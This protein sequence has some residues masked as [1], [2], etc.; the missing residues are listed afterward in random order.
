MDL[1]T[2]NSL[3]FDQT[4]QLGETITYDLVLERLSETEKTYHL[5]VLN[6]P[7]ELKVHFKDAEKGATVSAVKF[8]QDVT[9]KQL[10]MELVIP[11]E[12]PQEKLDKPVAFYVLVLDEEARDRL[13]TL[14]RSRAEEE[15]SEDDLRADRIAHER[16]VFTPKGVGR[17]ELSS[18]DLYN[19]I[20]AGDTLEIK[21]K[22]KNIGSVALRNIR[23]QLELPA[24]WEAN[25]NPEVIREL[26]L[27]AEETVAI[28]LYPSPDLGVGDYTVRVDADCSYEGQ[29]ITIDDKIVRIHV[30]SKA[31]VLGGIVLLLILVGALVGIAVFLVRLARR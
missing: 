23:V 26:E 16:V 30:E 4:G 3:N 20:T 21:F 6:L 28:D 22:V 29:K 9:K 27:A 7:P 8:A 10:G 18:P 2:V 14:K 11:E 5:S 15:I 19:E 24:D 1:P 17:C 31:N 25:T 12:V 13:L